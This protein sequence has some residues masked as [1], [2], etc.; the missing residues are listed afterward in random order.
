MK[1]SKFDKDG[2]LIVKRKK[3]EQVA[4]GNKQELKLSIWLMGYNKG[5]ETAAEKYGQECAARCNHHL[6]GVIV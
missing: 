6:H 1:Q 3:R 4:N 5:M 2:L